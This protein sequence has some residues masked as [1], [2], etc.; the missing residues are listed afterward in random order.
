MPK[1]RDRYQVSLK[2]LIVNDHREVLALNALPSGSFAGYFD[3]PGG[4]IDVREFQTPFA[5]IL[6]REIREELGDVEVEIR[7][8]P[9]AVG[10][11]L[12]A[13]ESE[14]SG[15]ESIHLLYLFFEAKYKGGNIV[16]GKEH[17]GFRWLDLTKHKLPDIFKSGLLEGVLMYIQNRV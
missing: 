7:P 4:R 10:R 13:A 3:L 6:L 9:V 17:S 16:T 8:V 1:Q 12:I 5:D 14:Q 11:H 15:G 2:A